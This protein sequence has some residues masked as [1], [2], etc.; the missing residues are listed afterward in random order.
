MALAR[1]PFYQY[2]QKF[3]LISLVLILLVSAVFAVI[4]G[5]LYGLAIFYIPFIYLNF[6]L[7]LLFG[8]ALGGLIGTFGRLFHIRNPSLI[9]VIGFV[10]GVLAYYVAW[11]MWLH[12]FKEQIAWTYVPM[13]VWRLV[14]DVARN[15]A[16]TF[17]SFTPTGLVLYSLWGI[18]SLTIILLSA[19]T[20]YGVIKSAPYCERCCCWL[21]GHLSYS[22][23]TVMNNQ[24]L[25]RLLVEEDLSSLNELT[26]VEAS[27]PH[28]SEIDVSYCSQCEN[29]YYLSFKD[30]IMT[31][32]KDGNQEAKE[33]VLIDNFILIPEDFNQYKAQWL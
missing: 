28:Y 14:E 5:A 30:I 2:S 17:K 7:T 1:S 11:V 19:I 31:T 4:L 27:E 10:I 18:E 22:P 33:T 26:P 24:I 16:W 8:F 15:G 9:W 12:Y 29:E 32:D 3:S 25:E 21:D 20:A 23:L 6:I 13:D